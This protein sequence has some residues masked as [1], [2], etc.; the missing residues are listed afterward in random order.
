MRFVEGEQIIQ[1]TTGPARRFIAGR[2]FQ[3]SRLRQKLRQQ[4]S[5]ELADLPRV[6]LDFPLS[7]I[8]LVGEC[9]VLQQRFGEGNS[10][11]GLFQIGVGEAQ[12][13][14]FNK[15]TQLRERRSV[16]IGTAMSE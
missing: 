10:L 8:Q 2:D 4:R 14:S 16:T 6:L 3:T 7:K 5:L 11:N 15:I 13:N 12:G 1:I 9:L